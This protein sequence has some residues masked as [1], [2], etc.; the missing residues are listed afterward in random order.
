MTWCSGGSGPLTTGS[1]APPATASFTGG[2]A[3]GPEE[4]RASVP[5]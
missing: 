5:Y 3:P 1:G 4:L 2:L